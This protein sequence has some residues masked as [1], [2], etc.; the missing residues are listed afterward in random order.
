MAVPVVGVE[1]RQRHARIGA[2]MLEPRAAVIEVDEHRPSSQRYQVATLSGPPPGFSD[3]ITAGLGSRSSAELIGKRRLG[4]PHTLP[5]AG[6]PIGGCAPGPLLA[7]REPA[8]PCAPMSTPRRQWTP[9]TIRTELLP[10]ATELAVS[11]SVTS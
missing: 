5:D 2:Q 1:H 7:A 8:V 4:H 3:A 11:R 9:E 10:V 6:R